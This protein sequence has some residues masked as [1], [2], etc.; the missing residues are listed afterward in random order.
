MCVR[1][2]PLTYEEAVAALGSRGRTGRSEGRQCRFRLPSAR[3][4]LRPLR[5]GEADAARRLGCRRFALSVGG[6]RLRGAPRGPGSEG[7]PMMGDMAC[8]RS[9][10][11]RR[12]TANCVTMSR[13][14]SSG[15]GVGFL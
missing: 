2:V 14:A 11:W 1:L 10:R 5:G 7:P 4:F 8:A 12:E 3:A 13:L 15:I 9:G 6:G